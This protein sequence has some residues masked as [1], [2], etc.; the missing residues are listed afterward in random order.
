[1]RSAVTA[2]FESRTNVPL[3]PPP[4]FGEWAPNSDDGDP[5]DA[6]FSR[7][8]IAGLA[9]GMEYRDETGEASARAIRCLAIDPEGPGY[10][11]AYCH[12]RRDRRTFRI[13][14]IR[15]VVSLR[16]G[17]ILSPEAA[18]LL[19]APYELPEALSAHQRTLATVVAAVKPGVSILLGLGMPEGR[20]YA[21]PRRAVLAYIMAEASALSLT[22]PHLEGIELF[23][24]NLSPPHTAVAQ[25]SDEIL[26]DREKFARLLPYV[27]EIAKLTP[28]RN[29]RDANVAALIAAVRE[30]YR[31]G[32]RPLPLDFA[33]QR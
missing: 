23:V 10:I 11:R 18:G 17:A 26:A 5:F 33:A 31:T 6:D 7:T 25:A 24:D 4:G 3:M 13:D 12:Y 30:H 29:L 14:G 20:L 32:A 19:L 8:D 1:M 2:W 15:S 27:M 16:S 9:F 28:H 22:L 21:E